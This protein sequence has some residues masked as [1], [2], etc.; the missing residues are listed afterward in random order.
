MA[1][2][3]MMQVKLLRNRLAVQ[4]CNTCYNG[5]MHGLFEGLQ[6]TFKNYYNMGTFAFFCSY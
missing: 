1:I 3:G 5:L 2:K 6:K 4:T